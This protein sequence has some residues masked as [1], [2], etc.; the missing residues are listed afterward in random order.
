[1]FGRMIRAKNYSA[2]H[3]SAIEIIVADQIDARI[4]VSGD[5]EK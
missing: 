2:G 3:D 1:M 5:T 4:H